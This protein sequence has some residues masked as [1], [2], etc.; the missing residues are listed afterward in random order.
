ML[1]VGL[2]AN[3]KPVYL[4]FSALAEKLFLFDQAWQ[5]AGSYPKN[6]DHEGIRDCQLTDL[7]KDGISELVVAFEGTEGIHLVDLQTLAGE[8]ISGLKATSLAQHGDDVVVTSESKLGMLRTGLT[9]VEETELSFR[10]VATM[11]RGLMCGMGITDQGRWNAVG[12]DG[13][14]K[15][16]WTL[17]IGSQ[18]F[19]T[20]LE[21]V[22]VVHASDGEFIWAIADTQ[23]AIH[24]VSGGGKWL[25]DFQSESQLAGVALANQN[26]KICLM[27]SNQTG[28]ECWDL[29]V[30]S[31][32]MRPASM[33]K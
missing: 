21:P 15:R 31:S 4:V 30:Q 3:K 5:P 16:I 8:K 29:N 2:D 13:D 6:S 24:L 22:S 18:F 11:G 33:R 23:D 19:E 27:V 32:P 17:S 12:F 25:G 7:N 26:G 1:R 14:L 10:R 9:N 20:E 28:I